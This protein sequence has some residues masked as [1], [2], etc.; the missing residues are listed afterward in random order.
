MA[1]AFR[2]KLRNA[3][4]QWLAWDTFAVG[5]PSSDCWVV[6]SSDIK[7]YLIKSA[8]FSGV[9]E[10]PE[11]GKNTRHRLKDMLMRGYHLRRRV[12]VG[13]RTLIW[14]GRCAGRASERRLGKRV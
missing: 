12:E 9:K 5:D 4:I 7:K 1:G 2:C 10:N 14:C 6:A 3:V 11:R 8:K 13:M